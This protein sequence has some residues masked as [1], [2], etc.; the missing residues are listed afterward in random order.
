MKLLYI[1][2]Q[3]SGPGGL[4]RVLSIKASYFADKLGH[5]VHILTLN[6]T[7]DSLFFDFSSAIQTHNIELKRSPVHY[8]KGYLK[9][10]K[11]T[12]SKVAPDIIL[13]C[14]D[15]LKGM[16]LPLLIGKSRPMI[17][18]RHVSKNI[19]FKNENPSLLQKLKNKIQF[20]LMSWGAS[21]YDAFVVLTNGNLKEWNLPN[22]TVIPN[23]LSFSPQINS[24]EKSKSVIAVGKHCFQKGYDLLVEAWRAVN[25]KHPDWKLEIYGTKNPHFS[26]TPMIDTYNLNSSIL[27]HNPT[28]DIA[29]EFQRTAIHVLSSRFEGFGMVITEAMACGL[30]SI[31]FDCPYGPSDIITDGE[32]GLLVKNGDTEALSNAICQL[33]EDKEFR[34]RLGKNAIE[35]INRYKIEEIANQWNSLFKSIAA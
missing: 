1:T 26:V 23:P 16:L 33:I 14:D 32:N 34:E 28:K 12:I 20:K 29:S 8:I 21:K 30:P 27:L 35:S 22:L 2:N 9:G 19:V 13:V 25:Q 24:L 31:S 6:D 15:G 7:T 3:I 17:Y 18:E 11:N 4:E 5:D 10:V